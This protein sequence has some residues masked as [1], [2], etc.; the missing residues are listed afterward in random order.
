MIS[1]VNQCPLNSSL[2]FDPSTSKDLSTAVNTVSDSGTTT[3]A[4]QDKTHS[5]VTTASSVTVSPTV[6][7]TTPVV[8]TPNVTTETETR[9]PANDTEGSD[10]PEANNDKFEGSSSSGTT[11]QVEEKSKET[12]VDNKDVATDDSSNVNQITE[13]P[14][15]P[16]TKPPLSPTGS[17]HSDS[18]ESVTGVSLVFFFD[19]I[20]LV[21]GSIPAEVKMFYIASFGVPFPY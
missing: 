15:A 11:V 20:L 9:K 17:L 3:T 13:A 7:M 2:Q 18:G 12:F 5:I 21:V 1:P 10:L 14:V 16:E 19:I 8:S 4:P 6:A